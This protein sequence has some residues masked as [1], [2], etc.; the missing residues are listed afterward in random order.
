MQQVGGQRTEGCSHP[1]PYAK[2]EVG[3]KKWTEMEEENWGAMTRIDPKR[4]REK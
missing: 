4:H 1:P 3:G 2:L